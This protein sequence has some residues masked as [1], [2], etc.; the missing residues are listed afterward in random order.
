MATRDNERQVPAG[1]IAMSII[2]V[3]VLPSAFLIL[4][5][6][7]LS[8]GF[9][10]TEDLKITDVQFKQSCLKVE[11]TN[12]GRGV[13]SLGEIALDEMNQTYIRRTVL[14][15]TL[16]ESVPAG[17]QCSISIGCEWISGF[18]YHITLTTT[19][20]NPFSFDEVAP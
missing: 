10:Q 14:R 19:K 5:L 4:S 2:S 13:V 17:E 9:P 15:A 18:T 6:G 11:V 7:D 20:G 1:I 16:D 12:N 8:I 3:L